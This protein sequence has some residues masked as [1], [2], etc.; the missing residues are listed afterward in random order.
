MPASAQTV[1]PSQILRRLSTVLSTDLSEGADLLEVT[2]VLVLRNLLKNF[3]QCGSK[4]YA[5]LRIIV[6]YIVLVSGI[7]GATLDL[8]A[9]SSA[10]KAVI[11][12]ITAPLTARIVVS[13]H[14]PANK[15]VLAWLA[16]HGLNKDARTLA[17]WDRPSGQVIYDEWGDVTGSEQDTFDQQSTPLRYIPDFGKYR[18]RFQGHFMSMER[19]DIEHVQVEGGPK[20][21][22]LE[23]TDPRRLVLEC[24]PTLQGTKP[25]KRFL[26]HVNGFSKPSR[27]NTT[28]I[29]HATGNKRNY[30]RDQV[31]WSVGAC[32]PA[33]SLDSV[34]LESSK[35]EA[36]VNDIAYYLTPECQR[37][38][39]N[40][41]Y[42]YRRGFLLYGPPGTGK[43]S[44]TVALAGHFDLDVYI[45]SMSD[46]DMSDQQLEILFSNLPDKCIVLLEDVDSAGLNR[47]PSTA[48][49][50]RMWKE[51]DNDQYVTFNRFADE[52]RS[53]LTL[54]GL[55]NC[56]DGPMSRDGR[57]VCLTSNAPD[58]FDPALVRPGRCDHKIL[59]GYASEEISTQLFEHLYT[60][61]SDEL[62]EGETSISDDHDIPS[63]AR[64]FAQAIPPDSMI[65]PAEV[66]GYLMIHR[67]DPQAALD[68]A[69]T[70]AAKIIETKKRGAN[71]AKHANEVD[72]AGR[73]TW[74]AGSSDESTEG[75][76]S[77]SDQSAEEEDCGRCRMS[78]ECECTAA[79]SKVGVSV[80]DASNKKHKS[81]SAEELSNGFLSHTLSL[82]R[83]VA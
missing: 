73:K 76:A 65:T 70:F 16:A 4:A 20:P 19:K 35:K 25:L 66:Q 59:F 15:D 56:I 37:F 38:Y 29:Y 12:W 67:Q 63:M 3:R 22:G 61:R 43:T 68:G 5:L 33:R 17:L 74:G 32:R 23:P 45:L 42:P 7:Y 28:T 52:H 50:K 54:S 30:G 24:F 13:A 80:E 46:K 14:S 53:D 71:V 34:A 41:G 21:E 62:V 51:G 26:D 48:E 81:L 10:F 79:D 11:T 78:S 49:L 36:V 44:F 82:L 77:D 57:I 64:A 75:C 55:L 69:S 18:F 27:E 83:M 6:P 72:R 39:A 8:K 58:S 40:R 31:D 2:Y 1:S 47:E 9:P 60:K